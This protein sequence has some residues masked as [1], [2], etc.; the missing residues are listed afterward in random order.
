V[1]AVEGGFRATVGSRTTTAAK[2]IVA[3]GVNDDPPPIPGLAEHWGRGV[4]TCPFCDGYEHADTPLVVTGS[5]QFAAHLGRLLTR[6][7]DDVTVYCDAL[8]AGDTAD[9]T[10]HGVRVDARPIERVLGEDG[11]AT[12]IRVGGAHRPVGAIFVA[13]LP[14]PN[15]ALAAS[16]GCAL[17]EHGFVVVDAMRRT[18]V[19][20]VWAIG[21]VANMRAN[22][23]MA[24]TDGVIAGVDCH[25]QLFE[26]EW[27]ET[28]SA[29]A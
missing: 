23:S 8:D 17:D 11:R 4:F 2:L 15:S 18:T 25:T 27:A 6:W 19:D 1:H 14:V 12:A 24:I 21:D 26:A 22:M 7:S 5:P 10:A 29:G 28:V 13:G 9:L 20:G 16:L 3:T